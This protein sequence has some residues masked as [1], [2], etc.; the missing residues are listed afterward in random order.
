M[1]VVRLPPWI[2]ARVDLRGSLVGRHARRALRDV[3]LYNDVKTLQTL[4]LVLP[5][6]AIGRIVLCVFIV[7]AV[8]CHRGGAQEGATIIQRVRAFGVAVR[9]PNG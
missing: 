9:K 3:A 4:L 1:Y 2:R 7:D 6:T 8:V 5:A